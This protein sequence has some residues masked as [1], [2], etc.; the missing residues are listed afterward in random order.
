MRPYNCA[1]QY[2]RPYDVDAATG[3][4][5][6]QAQ[7]LELSSEVLVHTNI[8]VYFERTIYFVYSSLILYIFATQKVR[9]T[10]CDNAPHVVLWVLHCTASRPVPVRRCDVRAHLRVHATRRAPIFRVYNPGLQVSQ[11]PLPCPVIYSISRPT[12]TTIRHV[13]PLLVTSRS[14]RQ[15]EA[16]RT[17]SDFRFPPAISLS[18]PHHT[19]VSISD[20]VS[21]IPHHISALSFGQGGQPSC[22]C[23][24]HPILTYTHLLLC[25][26]FI[27]FLGLS[28]LRRVA[29]PSCFLVSFCVVDCCSALTLSLS[30][31]HVCIAPRCLFL[32]ATLPYDLIFAHCTRASRPPPPLP[33]AILI[34][35]SLHLS[36]L[37]VCP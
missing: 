2:C 5:H 12:S 25:L 16:H 6:S 17:D 26:A 15:P 21:S 36:R 11:S 27:S 14:C 18:I 9:D 10:R 33:P 4:P 3:R 7:P 28:P 24:I 23:T 35:T 19:V 22:S 30:C 32:P 31:L 20:L 29:F 13:T 34:Y 1:C 37:F 8:P